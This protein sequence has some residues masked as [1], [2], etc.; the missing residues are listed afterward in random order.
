METKLSVL[1]FSGLSFM[2]IRGFILKEMYGRGVPI[3]GLRAQLAAAVICIFSVMYL[4]RVPE[5]G[6]PCPK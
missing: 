2:G 5:P 6:V 4:Y 1:F 3:C